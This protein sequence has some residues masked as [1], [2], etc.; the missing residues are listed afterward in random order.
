MEEGEDL[1]FPKK[2]RV[3]PGVN[4]GRWVDG[5]GQMEKQRE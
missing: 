1:N 2:W 3:M 5:R 4:K